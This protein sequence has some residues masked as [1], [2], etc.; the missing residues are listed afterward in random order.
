VEE[1]KCYSHGAKFNDSAFCA[2]RNWVRWNGGLGVSAAYIR[3]YKAG[4]DF[5]GVVWQVNSPEGERSNP[6]F[7]HRVRLQIESP[8]SEVDS[9]LNDLKLELINELLSQELRQKI[10]E[11]G[12]RYQ[13]GTRLSEQQI[14]NNKATTVFAVLLDGNQI[15]TSVEQTIRVVHNAIGPTVGSVV[16]TISNRLIKRF[17]T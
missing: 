8:T 7:F 1:I 3:S 5:F 9:Y 17:G 11:T 16:D 6:E 13:P 15:K 10:S 14:R 12:F 2:P 4:H